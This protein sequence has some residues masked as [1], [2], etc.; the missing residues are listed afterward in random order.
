MQ[1]LAHMLFMLIGQ[2]VVGYLLGLVI[3]WLL[4]MVLA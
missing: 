3:G 2:L 1:S 4:E